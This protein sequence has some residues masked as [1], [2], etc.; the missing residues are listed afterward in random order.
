MESHMSR[1]TLEPV[2]AAEAPG[3]PA[4]TPVFASTSG[5]RARVVRWGALAVAA[6]TGIWIV[7]LLAGALGMGHLPG[8][9]LPDVG[10]GSSPTSDGAAP[11]SAAHAGDRSSAHVSPRLRP[12]GRSAAK[13]LRARVPSSSRSGVP[14]PGLTGRTDP[15][16]LPAPTT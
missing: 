12:T 11:T 3:A 4:G 9:S 7:A 8:V 10:N 1:T 6:L 15:R 16:T 2:P 5:R 14:T 13:R